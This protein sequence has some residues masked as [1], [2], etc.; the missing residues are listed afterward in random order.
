MK[1]SVSRWGGN[2]KQTSKRHKRNLQMNNNM[3]NRTSQNPGNQTWIGNHGIYPEMC[4][5]LSSSK[6]TLKGN[7]TNLYNHLK[8]PHKIHYPIIKLSRPQNYQKI[9]LPDLANIYKRKCT[10]A[11]IMLLKEKDITEANFLIKKLFP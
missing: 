10:T 9:A 2:G 4:V 7:T 5:G 3:Q 1:K 6:H 8:H 11:P